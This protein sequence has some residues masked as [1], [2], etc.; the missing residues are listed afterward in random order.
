MVNADTL[1]GESSHSCLD[2]LG[3]RLRVPGPGDPDRGRARSRE[4][5]VRGPLWSPADS[6]SRDKHLRALIGSAV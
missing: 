6:T 3:D 2:G 1:I 5:E 4:R